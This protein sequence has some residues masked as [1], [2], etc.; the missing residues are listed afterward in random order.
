MTPHTNRETKVVALT[1]PMWAVGAVSP[2]NKRTVTVC[3][4]HRN[5][6]LIDLQT[7]LTFIPV[8]SLQ[9]SVNVPVKQSLD[10][11][12]T[13]CYYLSLFISVQR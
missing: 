1:P 3:I 12:D 7:K 8:V 6:C 4:I 13:L 9:E 2:P 11:L 10:A 5:I